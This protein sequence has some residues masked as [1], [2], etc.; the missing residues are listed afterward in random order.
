MECYWKITFLFLFYHTKEGTN[1]YSK[2]I[3]IYAS[4]KEPISVLIALERG[5][6]FFYISVPTVCCLK[7]KMCNEKDFLTSL[8]AACALLNII[9]VPF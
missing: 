3:N 6:F 5:C 7:S 4:L 2:H 1:S 8:I 9:N